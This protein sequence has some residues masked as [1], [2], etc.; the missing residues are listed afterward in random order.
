MAIFQLNLG[1]PLLKC[2]HSGFNRG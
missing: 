1:K 2:Y